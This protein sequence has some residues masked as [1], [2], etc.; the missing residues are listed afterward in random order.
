MDHYGDIGIDI[1]ERGGAAIVVLEG[2]VDLCAAGQFEQALARA[3]ASGAPAIVLDLDRV[4]FMDA[5]GVH[6]LLDFSSSERARDRLALT[7]GSGQVR[8]L[9]EVT[10]VRRYL[11]FVESCEV[12]AG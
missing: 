10:G 11:R 6:V 12:S 1:V 8:R 3:V 7:R 5:A 2:E 9:L 4:T